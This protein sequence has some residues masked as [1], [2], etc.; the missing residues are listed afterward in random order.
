MKYFYIVLIL[1]VFSSSQLFACDVNLMSLISG[2]RPTDDFTGKVRDLVKVTSE[3]GEN[4]TDKEKSSAALKKLMLDWVEFDT[5]YYQAP[6][7]WAKKDKNWK[8][9]IKAVADQIGIVTKLLKS[10]KRNK[11]HEEIRT[12]ASKLT[13]LLEYLPMDPKEKLLMDFPIKFDM[14]RHAFKN[15]NTAILGKLIS[16]LVVEKNK[17]R[18]LIGSSSIKLTDEFSDRIEILKSSYKNDAGKLN[19]TLKLNIEFAEDAFNNMRA[20]V[21]KGVKSKEKLDAK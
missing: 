4:T 8:V 9:K 18:S 6:P 19:T 2:K 13:N 12:I 11:A 21:I 16:E 5:K 14:M 7:E 15:K 3:L 1:L 10:Y 20:P 17:L